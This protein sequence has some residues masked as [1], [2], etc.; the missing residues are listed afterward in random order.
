MITI[1]LEKYF[2]INTQDPQEPSDIIYGDIVG[3]TIGSDS[4]T[5]LIKQNFP[6][7]IDGCKHNVN[8]RFK[9]TIEE[10]QE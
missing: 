10:I 3:E 4:L 1:V 5:Q 2:G 9:I 8:S 7:I 6:Y